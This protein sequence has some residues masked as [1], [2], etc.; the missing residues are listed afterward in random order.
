MARPICE[1]GVEAPAV[2]PMRT[3]PSGSQPVSSTSSRAPRGVPA[4]LW[5]RTA[6]PTHS[7]PGLW[8]ARGARARLLA[9]FAGVEGGAGGLVA[10]DVALDAVAAGYVV[11]RGHPLIG[12]DRE[13]VR[14]GGVVAADDDHDVDGLLQ[15]AEER[16]LAGRGGR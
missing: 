10:D 12:D 5:R 8:E 13:V 2:R 16:G 15:K 1:F 11:A 9:L 7:P 6:P 3:G 14:V 4:G